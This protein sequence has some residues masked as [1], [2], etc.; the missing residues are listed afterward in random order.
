MAEMQ[1]SL[2]GTEAV[3]NLQ[4]LEIPLPALNSKTWPDRLWQPKNCSI[5]FWQREEREQMHLIHNNIRMA[6]KEPNTNKS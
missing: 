3:N 6:I 4:L 5:F 1:L 2:K